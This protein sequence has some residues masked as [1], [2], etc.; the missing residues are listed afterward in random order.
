MVAAHASTDIAVL[1][2]RRVTFS[3]MELEERPGPPGPYAAPG[4]I[5]PPRPDVSTGGT[6]C[7][8]IEYARVMGFRPLRMDLLLPHGLDDSLLPPE[9]SALMHEALQRVGATSEVEW[10][11]G[12]G[13]VFFGVDPD[14]IADRSADSL[15]RHLA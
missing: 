15:V 8:D 4:E 2:Q 12:A 5:A 13:H 1:R 10:I 11:E 6:R 14:P 3:S 7:A 9:Q